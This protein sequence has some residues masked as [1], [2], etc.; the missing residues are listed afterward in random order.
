MSQIEGLSGHADGD[1]IIG[2]LRGFDKAPAQ[3]FVVHGE[4]DASDTLRVRIQDELDWRVR[5][6]EH[7]SCVEV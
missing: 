1:G 7:G 6:P 2:W 5:S 4:R 3:T